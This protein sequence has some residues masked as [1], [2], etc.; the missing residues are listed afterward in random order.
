[1]IKR[2]FQKDSLQLDK[3]LKVRKKP[4]IIE[5]VQILELFEVETME[6]VMQGKVGD[7]LMKG[8]DGELYVC[9][10]DIFYRTY[11]IIR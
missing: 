8:I 9:D 11:D 5:A 2:F 1:M 10:K 6:G 3:M 4:I 7:F